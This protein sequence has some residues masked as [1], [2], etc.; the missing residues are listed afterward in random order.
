MSTDGRT[1]MAGQGQPMA[2]ARSLPSE[3]APCA[4]RPFRVPRAHVAETSE[5]EA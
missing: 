1:D 4:A 5:S 3:T 2:P